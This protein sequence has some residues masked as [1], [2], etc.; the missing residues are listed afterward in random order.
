MRFVISRSL[1]VL[2][3]ILFPLTLSAQSVEAWR[4]AWIADEGGEHIVLYL[5]LRDG[6]VSGTWC[7]S[8]ANP[9]RLAFVD[10]GTLDAGGLHYNL[11]FSASEG[12]DSVVPVDARLEGGAL[13]VT[14]K[15]PESETST[16]VMRRAPPQPVP[17]PVAN[18]RPNQAAPG[19][20]RTLPGPAETVTA[21]KV[22][23]LWLWGTGPTKQYFIFKRHKDGVRGM[24]C[25]PCDS[26]QDFAPLENITMQGTNFHFDIIHEDNG[27]G[28]AENGPF[29][30]VTDAQITLNEMHMTTVASFAPEGRKFEMTLLG[31]TRY[32]PGT[33]P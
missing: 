20:A 7:S 26:A 33:T 13:H 31:P 23:G 6:K 17:P 21:D 1:F 5:V 15:L 16:L 12:L 30:N 9:D 2:G 10:D 29:S 8:C 11:Y 28:F 27:I 25:G 14:L 19:I 18:A 22:L 24:V 3:A 32:M 4:G